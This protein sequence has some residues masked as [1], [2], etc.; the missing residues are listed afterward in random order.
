M[1]TKVS[2]L[3]YWVLTW[4]SSFKQ[5]CGLDLHPEKP[6]IYHT[7]QFWKFNEKWTKYKRQ[8]TYTRQVYMNLQLN[9]NT[10][11]Y[12]ISTLPP[13]WTQW[14]A[15]AVD[16]QPASPYLVSFP[17]QRQQT[18][19]EKYKQPARS[20]KNENTHVFLNYMDI[21]KTNELFCLASLKKKIVHFLNWILWKDLIY[22]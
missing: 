10:P 22:H 21:C 3:K 14:G 2:E 19:S 8:W 4:K 16:S 9:N 15:V 5:C 7:T 18:R 13:L 6:K 12:S 1:K 20:S 11:L 17:S